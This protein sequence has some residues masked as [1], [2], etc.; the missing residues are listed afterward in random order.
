MQHALLG[1]ERF[2]RGMDLYFERH[3]G[4]AVTCDDFVQAMQDA[5]DI[6][7]MQFRRW[8]SQAG[9]PVVTAR[10]HYDA[11]MRSFTL[12]VEQKT[13]PT[14]GQTDKQPVHIPFA[15]GLLDASGSDL[16]L[17]LAGETTTGPTT[18]VLD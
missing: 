2:R 5:S 13:A 18:R 17:T 1:A 4:R 10:G 16:P 15:V 3:D 14:P 7:L 6:D 9:T 8:Y 12:E 11:A